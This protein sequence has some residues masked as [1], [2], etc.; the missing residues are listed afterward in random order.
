[1]QID[2]GADI[3]LLPAIVVS[4]GSLGLVVGPEMEIVGVD[5]RPI[6]IPTVETQMI[7]DSYSFSGVYGLIDTEIGILGRDVLNQLIL[8]LD[9]PEET[10][11]LIESIERDR[12]IA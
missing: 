3:S 7:L 6:S 1:M 4:S 2:T 10:L 9:G 11:S 8:L 12:L 5:D